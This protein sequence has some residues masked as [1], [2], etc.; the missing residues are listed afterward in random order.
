MR[1]DRCAAVLVLLGAGITTGPVCGHAD[2][3]DRAAWTACETAAL[4][5]A[6]EY[7]DHHGALYRGSCRSMSNTLLCVRTEPIER[8]DVLSEAL[9]S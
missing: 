6:C 7:T 1:R 9:G 4:T 2:A 8:V 3:V 5:D